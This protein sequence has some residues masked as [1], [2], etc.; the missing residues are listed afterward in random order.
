MK[1]HAPLKVVNTLLGRA[2][3]QTIPLSDRCCGESGTFSITR[4]DI[5]TQTR[6][7]K[8]QEI[9]QGTN[10]LRADGFKGN[11]KLLTACP[12]CLQGLSRYRKDARFRSDYV[13]I[14][15]ARHLLG[16]Q[17]LIDYVRKVNTG[18]I[19]RVIL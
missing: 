11:I 13:L 1:T 17:W 18:G 10:H 4:P 16:E 6:F 19:E 14:E 8:Q 12:S 5:A 2:E 9:E 15:L 3:S 7:R